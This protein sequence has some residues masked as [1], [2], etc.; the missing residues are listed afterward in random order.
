MGN[1]YRD[2]LG[3]PKPRDQLCSWL[4]MKRGGHGKG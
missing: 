1:Q 3:Q 4:M 2:G